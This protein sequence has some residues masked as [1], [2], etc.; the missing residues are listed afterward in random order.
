M[1]KF[2]SKK[3]TFLSALIWIA[4]LLCA[5]TI[6]QGPTSYESF[7]WLLLCGA[8]GLA[9]YSFG[10]STRKKV[11]PPLREIE[12]L[13]KNRSLPEQ[14]PWPPLHL[15]GVIDELTL[16]HSSNDLY[17]RYQ[18]FIRLAEDGLQHALGSCCVTLW[19]LDHDQKHL[20]ECVIPQSNQENTSHRSA[21]SVSSP[22][23]ISLDC[24]VIQRGLKTEQ[25]TL[26]NSPD[27]IEG[28]L[29]SNGPSLHCDACIPLYRDYG[30]PLVVAV[31]QNEPFASPGNIESFH[32]TAALI[33]LFWEQLQAAN[34]RQ[35]QSEHDE[36]DKVL[37]EEAFLEHAQKHATQAIG[38]DELFCLVVVT[39][40]G[41]RSL[42]SGQSQKWRLLSNLTGQML[43]RCLYGAKQNFLLGKMSNDVFAI[44]LHGSDIFIAKAIMENILVDLG[45][46]INHAPEIQSLELT[47]IELQWSVADH[48][49]YRRSIAEMLDDMYGG[50]F[51][52]DPDKSVYEHRITI[53]NSLNEVP[54]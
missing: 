35:W 14:N 19:C 2:Q 33:Q 32:R 53:E 3:K 36:T 16:L 52:P 27:K 13:E 18:C 11:L 30:Q 1:N 29:S 21:N 47:S 34:Q 28:L 8:V 7:L 48:Q 4:I 44:Y 40:R 49:N 42:F 20:V 9:G 24:Q 43:N 51:S 5:L 26:A 31:Q 41:F 37:R 39:L 6:G 45:Q 46:K 38:R 22:Y 23:R 50:L 12:D 15:H 10:V 54:V 25:P 17:E